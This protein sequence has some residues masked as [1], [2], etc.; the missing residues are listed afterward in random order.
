MNVITPTA[1]L[2]LSLELAACI[3]SDDRFNQLLATIR[4]T[5]RCEAVAV[6]VFKQDHLVLLALQGL[7]NE[8]LGRR[9]YLEQHPRF[10]QICQSATA[11]RFSADCDLPD[12]Y[13]GLLLDREGDLPVHACMGIPL[14]YNQQLIGVLTLD[15]L[16]P[17]VFDDINQRTLDLIGSMAAV[18]LNSALQMEQLEKR[19]QH[20]T[21]VV[22]AMSDVNAI[23]TQHELI[24]QSQAMLKLKREISL[25]APSEFTVLIQGETGTGK[26]LVAHNIHTLSNRNQAPIIY[27]NCAALPEKLVESELFGHVKGA[28]TGA[29]KNRAG[30]F[31]IADGGTLFLDEIGEL[32]LSV[33]SK[34]LRALQSNEIQA[35]GQDKI[36]NV[37][38]RVIAATNRDLESEVNAGRFRSDLYH[39]LNVYPIT[40][41]KLSERLGDI[42]ILSGFFLEKLKRKLGL[43]QLKLSNQTLPIL[44]DYHWPG[45][46]RE[47][48]HVISRAALTASGRTQDKRM[49]QIKVNDLESLSTNNLQQVDT[50]S[51][52]EE[53]NQK[54][55]N[56]VRNFRQE[57]DNFQRNLI[58]QSLTERNGNWTAT[59]K[60]LQMDRANLNRLAKRLNISVDKVVK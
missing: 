56:Q 28:F 35:V 47:L 4:K 23:T 44:N 37:N 49:V 51:T 39:R 3:T 5:I 42:D 34:L 8:T 53:T 14:Q 41:P 21:Q 26:E 46:V 13:D 58:H 1:L 48:E 31:Q 43:G 6:L 25:V 60:A 57:V 18:S 7:S 33:Q 2:E 36:I 50:K 20:S 29:E 16:T 19:V 55:T 15:S 17:G 11:T 59:A 24:G 10:Q 52:Q 32:P 22:A 12:P 27:V 40:V 54:E 9:F 30:K 38:V 45:N